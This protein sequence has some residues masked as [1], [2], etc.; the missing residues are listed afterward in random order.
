MKK[1]IWAKGRK[2]LKIFLSHIDVKIIFCTI[3]GFAC[4]LNIFSLLQDCIREHPCIQIK[5][6]IIKN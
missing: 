3:I 2:M 5:I 6:K 4:K 1:F